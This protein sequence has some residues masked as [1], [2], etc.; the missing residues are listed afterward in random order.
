VTGIVQRV[1][2]IG[3]VPNI[4]Q[5]IGDGPINMAPSKQK[6]KI[7]EKKSECTRELIKINNAT[8]LWEI[9]IN[10]IK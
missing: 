8:N 5:K 10:S 6:K 3:G 1:A 7:K 4:P 9:N 2:S